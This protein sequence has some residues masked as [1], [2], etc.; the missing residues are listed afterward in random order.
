M[1]TVTEQFT[2]KKSILNNESGNLVMILAIVTMIAG[3]IGYWVSLSSKV[4]NEIRILGASQV[5]TFLRSDFQNTIK[6]ALQGRLTANCPLVATFQS[7]FY[8]FANSDPIIEKNYQDNLATPT[9]EVT[10]SPEIKCFF[11]PS[12]YN[13]LNWEKVKIIIRRTTEPNF[14]TLSSFIAADVFASFKMGG[15]ISMQKYQFKYR[16]DVLTLDHFG[17]IFTKSN[18][19]GPIIELQNDSEVKINSSVLFDL[20]SRINSSFSLA[21]MMKL[22]DSQKL[23]YLKEVYTP[24]ASFTTSQPIVDFLS[25]K[26]LSGVFKRGIQYNALVKNA[27]FKLPYEINDSE[28]KEFL[29]MKPIASD[30]YPLPNTNVASAIYNPLTAQHTHT[31]S[32][33]R[34]STALTYVAMYGSDSQKEVI[35]SCK[36]VLDFA[37]GVYNIY[38]FNHLDQDFTIDLSNNKEEGYPPFFCGLIAAKNLTVILNDETASSAFYQHHLIGKFILSGK[39]IVKKR[40]RLNIHDLM[41][42][43]EDE[44]EY[45]DIL[46]DAQNLRTQFFNQKYYSAQNFF[47][48]VFKPSLYPNVTGT[49]LLS[50]ADRFYVSRSTKAFFVNNCAGKKCRTPDILSPA[51]EDLAT[52]HKGNLVFEV[53]DVE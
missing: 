5:S 22:P 30:G 10:S 15:K 41:E 33:D 38:I 19:T 42:F 11:N 46:V 52:R 16:L 4:D 25:T 9:N 8:N 44:I 51:A 20:P 18:Q 13:N 37:S 48:P 35:Q 23:V 28:W 12:R 43:T 7:S 24:A 34:L 32:V 2:A 49:A 50:S 14:M 45:T 6:K 21:S 27:N 36:K 47:L 1:E 31:Y 17:M 26:A 39:L 53:Y 29:D 40:G 3:A